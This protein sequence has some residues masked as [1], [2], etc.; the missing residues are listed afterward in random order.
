M[1]SSHKTR[2]RIAPRLYAELNLDLLDFVEKRTRDGY[3]VMKKCSWEPEHLIGYNYCRT[4][5]NYETGV[6]FFIDDY[7][8][9]RCWTRPHEQLPILAKFQG[10]L[11]PDFSLF[12][13]MPLVLQ[14][15]NHYRQ[16]LLGC[17]WQSQGL[18]VIPTI[19]WSDKRSYDWCFQG[20]PQ[21]GTHAITTIGVVR[22]K[23]ALKHWRDGLAAYLDRL[24][25]DKL[26]IVGVPVETKLLDGLDVYW[27]YQRRYV[28]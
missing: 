2:V 23:E 21:G 13:D 5:K 12:R 16:Q 26:V 9:L 15:Y 18:N 11:T 14:K 17:F 27:I 24:Q 10:V 8:F 22:D 25:P 7:Q 20:V 6:H 4:A 3:P 28:S 19:S 1:A